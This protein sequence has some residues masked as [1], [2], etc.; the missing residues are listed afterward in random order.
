[1]I[2]GFESMSEAGLP[3]RRGLEDIRLAG[4][5]GPAVVQERAS[6]TIGTP[7]TRRGSVSS[8]T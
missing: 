6:S 4:L 3:D 5:D 7:R 1:M 2:H 8:R